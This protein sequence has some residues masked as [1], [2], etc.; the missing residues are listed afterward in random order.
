MVMVS[1]KLI[2]ALPASTRIVRLCSLIRPLLFS[3]AFAAFDSCHVDLNAMRR[4]P[5][6]GTHVQEKKLRHE[7]NGAAKYQPIIPER[8]VVEP[9]GAEPEPA[10]AQKTVPRW[11]KNRERNRPT[12][13]RVF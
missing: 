8:K 9:V 1:S 7:L 13:T 5:A 10:T 6:P 12:S 4:P 2:I 11:M 3:P